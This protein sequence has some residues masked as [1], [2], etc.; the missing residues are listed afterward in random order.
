MAGH[1]SG[2][3][4]RFLCPCWGDCPKPDYKARLRSFAPRF[5]Y[6]H[7]GDSPATLTPPGQPP[8]QASQ[9]ARQ[10]AAELQK[11]GPREVEFVEAAYGALWHPK[12]PPRFEALY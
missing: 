6:R 7:F 5:D 10:G 1:G 12:I 3:P 4:Q 9:R 8:Q 2:P 11:T